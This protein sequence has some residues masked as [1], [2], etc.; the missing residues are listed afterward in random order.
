MTT[1]G[2]SGVEGSRP[3]FG[4]TG[5]VD[6]NRHVGD[7][8]AHEPVGRR[9]QPADRTGDD[10]ANRFAVP[11]TQ[12]RV[13]D[14]SADGIRR[15]LE[16]SMDRLGLDHLDVCLHDPDDHAG[17][18]FREDCPALAEFRSEGVVE[19]TGAGTNQSAMLTRFVRDTD[20]DVVL[21]ADRY[22]LLDQSA[23]A[24]LFPAAI[25]RGTSVV[26]GGGVNSDLPANPTPTSTYGVGAAAEI[27]DCAEQFA[28]HVPAAFWRGLRETGLLPTEESS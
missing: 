15:G 9:L 6:L 13:R 3:S 12:G 2:R 27:R 10:L 26:I 11:G 4:A 8:E 17:Q 24:D 5:I 7:E 28:I 21:Y 19:A 18:A 20:V 16:A 25:E 14:F 23:L 1:L 22:T